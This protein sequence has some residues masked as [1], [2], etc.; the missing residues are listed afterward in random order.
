[1]SFLRVCLVLVVCLDMELKFFSVSLVFRAHTIPKQICPKVQRTAASA[2]HWLSDHGGKVSDAKRDAVSQLAKLGA[3]GRCP[4]NAERDMHRALNRMAKAFKAKISRIPIRL[5]DPSTLEVRYENFPMILPE[6][7]CLAMWQLGPS[8][9]RR[10]FFGDLRESDVALYWDNIA[11]RC[12]WFQNHPAK[13]WQHRG[14][15]ASITT[16]GDEVRAYQNSECGILSIVGW[17]SDLSYKADPLLRYYLLALWSEHHEC[18][19]TYDDVISCLTDSLLRLTDPTVQ[20]PWSPYGYLFVCSG[21]SGDLKWITDRMH[22]VHNFRANAFCSRC[23]CVKVREDDDRQFTL[24]YF[25]DDAAAHGLRDYTGVDMVQRFSP[26]FA[27]P[28]MD[29]TMVQHD[30]MHSQY[31]GTG[32]IVNGRLGRNMS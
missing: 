15:M 28:A 26:L 25:P 32:K 31:L 11:E 8:V 30:V 13:G 24:P 21:I 14:R 6:D 18:D 9:F 27:L 5:W 29:M 1:M 10:C 12:P 23:E 3:H 19:H 2:L 22:G 17:S 4:Q 16:Y 20:W 7:I